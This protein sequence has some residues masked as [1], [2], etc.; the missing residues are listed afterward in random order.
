MKPS[1]MKQ[2]VLKTNLFYKTFVV[3]FS[4]SLLLTSCKS[5]DDNN[6]DRACFE[7]LGSGSLEDLGVICVGDIDDEGE[8]ITEESLAVA[9][10]VFTLFG[11][12]CTEQ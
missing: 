4:F 1:I 2:P 6:D 9:V 7:C 10:S 5:D 8:T 3:L 12:T 11:G